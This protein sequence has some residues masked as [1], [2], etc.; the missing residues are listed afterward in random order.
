MGRHHDSAFAYSP[1][2]GS[3]Q[4][5]SLSTG[6]HTSGL[7]DGVAAYTFGDWLLLRADTTWQ[8]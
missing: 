5:G 7:I 1:S 3:A 4:E 8:V 2:A 6:Q